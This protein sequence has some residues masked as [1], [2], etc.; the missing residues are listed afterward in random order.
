MDFKKYKET[1]KQIKIGKQL[2]DAV[3]LHNT[4]LG[5][6]PPVLAA[7]TFKIADVLK[8]PDD[9]WNLVKFYKLDFKLAFLN[10]PTFEDEAYPALHHSYTVDL[11]KLSVRK[12]DYSSSE[13]PPILHRK[14]TF[15]LDIHPLQSLFKEFTAEG[16]QLGLYENTRNIGFKKNWLRLIAQKGYFI[17]EDGHLAPLAEKPVIETSGTTDIERHRTAIDRNQLS[18]PMQ[19]LARHN[20]LNGEYSVLDYGCG[21]GDDARELEAHGIN[22]CSWDPVHNPEGELAPSD[23]VNLGFVLNV[24]EERSERDETLRRAYSYAQKLLT[25]SVM[26]AG[27]SVIS[28]FKPY[29]DGVVTSRNTFQKY[30]SQG[31]IRHYIESILD[32]SVVAVGQGIFIIFKDKLEEQLFLAERQHVRRDWQQRTQRERLIPEKPVTRDLIAK[33][34]AL[35]DDYWQLTLDLGRIPA[36]TEFEF[37]DRL[38]SVAGSYKKAHD[39]LLEHHGDENYNEAKR[40]RRE[41][42]LVYFALAQFEKRKHYSQM[43]ESMKR[44]IK[45]FFTSYNDA[46]D[47]SRKLLFSVGKNETIVKA[48]N[49][50]YQALGCGEMNEGHSYTFHKGYLGDTPP[51][52]R[53]FVGCAIQLYGDIDNIH[54]IKAHMTS[55]KVTLLRYDDWNKDEPMLHERIKIKL[56]EQDIDFFEYSG[57]YSPQPLENKKLFN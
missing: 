29:K 19:V 54:L 8:I 1:V 27:D 25:V 55:G 24:I 13:N 49:E 20:Y 32:E 47:E 57:D 38:R 46:Q 36:N 35:F 39:A 30:Y 37:S 11:Q 17:A 48:C 4:A 3:Y 41:D 22:I 45:A 33:H 12:A 34:Q 15:V 42:L 52:L 43:P 7:V 28:Q 53:V 50:T 6:L 9:A 31:E 26:V 10:Y 40:K 5:E 16:E 18:A 14:E 56:R 2:P 44:D 21:K 23:I 51:E